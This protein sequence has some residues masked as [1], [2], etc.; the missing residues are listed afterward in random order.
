MSLRPGVLDAGVSVQATRAA[1]EGVRVR[2]A[3]GSG[4]SVAGERRFGTVRAMPA[5]AAPGSPRSR[6][7]R[8]PLARCVLLAGCAKDAPRTRGSPRATN[9][10][11]IQNLQW[12]VFVDRRHR[13]PASSSRP[14]CGACSATATAARRSRS[15]S[16]GNRR[17]R[18]R[19]HDPAG[20]HPGRR[21][22]R[23][24]EHADGALARPTTPSASST[25]PASSGGG[26][27]TTRCRTGCGGITEP[28]VTSGQL[29][30]PA[31]TNVLLRGTSRD[32]IHSFWV[33]EINGKRDM[34]PGRVQ[35][36]RL[37]ADAARHLRRPVR[38]VL[39]ALA[40]Q[41]AHGDRRR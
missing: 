29:V 26:R 11:K 1:S 20:A 16:H 27:S 8:S 24:H 32:V 33:P 10:Q 7:G 34:V 23:Q 21:R 6:V 40:R 5:E 31:D 22:R 28:I 4:H 2:A 30:I 12:P 9:A 14:S 36:L 41:H 17:A 39:R 3:A 19:P 37:Q 13:R 15:R 18:D 25:S 35:T 38:R